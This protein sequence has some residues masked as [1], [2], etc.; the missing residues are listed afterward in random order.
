[1]ARDTRSYYQRFL[2]WL[3][4]IDG[5]PEEVNYLK[6]SPEDENLP[7]VHPDGGEIGRREL[8]LL[9]F[10]TKPDRE[11]K[12]WWRVVFLQDSASWYVVNRRGEIQA[13]VHEHATALLGR[14]EAE[15]YVRKGV[16]YLRAKGFSR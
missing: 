4:G 10:L 6:W 5:A 2:D 11:R 15:T 14:G 1:M 7:I 3:A 9:E 16:L 12:D 13:C 8:K